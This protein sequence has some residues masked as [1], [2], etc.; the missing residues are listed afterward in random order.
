MQKCEERM[1]EMKKECG[2]YGSYQVR[3]SFLKDK[4][5]MKRAKSRNC[6]REIRQLKILMKK[7]RRVENLLDH[8][9]RNEG[10]EKRLLLW[11]ALIG[12]ENLPMLAREKNMDPT[13]LKAAIDTCLFEIMIDH[14]TI[15]RRSA[16]A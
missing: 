16:Y 2:N 3:S 11:R 14:M 10:I 7:M 8:V 5:R 1:E 13:D 12:R 15:G 9:E 6:T 4:I